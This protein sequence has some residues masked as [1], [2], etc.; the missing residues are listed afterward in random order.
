[1]EVYLFLEERGE[2]KKTGRKYGGGE[3]KARSG[4]S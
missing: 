3:R 1:M 4:R 2:N